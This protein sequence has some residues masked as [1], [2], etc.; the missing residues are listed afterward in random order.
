MAGLAADSAAGPA[1][2]A[3]GEEDTAM[4]PY[5]RPGID[6]RPDYE[7]ALSAEDKASLARLASE[8][9]RL[10]PEASAAQPG[11]QSA[12]LAADGVS[13]V[14][15]AAVDAAV[16][17]YASSFMDMRDPMVSAD[18][19]RPSASDMLRLQ[20]ALLLGALLSVA[21]WTTLTMIALPNQVARVHGF[22]TASDALASQDAAA[23]AAPLAWTVAIGALFAVLFTPFV[24]TISDHTRLPVGRRTPWLV[25]GGL[26]SALFALALGATNASVLVGLLWVLLQ[27]TYA[28]VAAPLAAAIAERVPD[29]FR[30][31]T[32]RWH[33]V[34]VLAGQ[35]AGGV[36]GGLSIAFGAFDPFLCAA[37]MFALSG[38]VVVLVWPREASSSSQ[39]LVR[40]AWGQVGA[41]LRPPLGRGTRAFHTL[42]ASRLFMSAAAGT[43]GAFL[44]YVVRFA[45]YGD[46]PRFTSAPVTLPAGTLLSLLAVASFAGALL[47]TCCGGMI[48]DK[49]AEG[50]GAWWRGSRSAVALACAL[51][52]LGLCLGLAIVLY[53]GEKS[54]TAFSFVA[55]FA[56]GMYDVLVQP[57]VVDALPDP[58]SAGRDLGVYATARPLGLALGTAAGAWSAT[59]LGDWTHPLSAG[60]FGYMAVFP[61]GIVCVALAVLCVA[62]TP[63]RGA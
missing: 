55:G 49:F 56:A 30:D 8:D 15:A 28:M 42:Y 46:M 36:A 53:G 26:L 12:R 43:T 18:G 54:L 34:G 20:W 14:A 25:G 5:R 39:P 51:Y 61:A 6:D 21:P 47:A 24:S 31:E 17:D 10:P 19:R 44:W 16:P 1:V 48:T 52:A 29:K 60:A 3:S 22:D 58:R 2:G 11:A 41:A 62:L 23:L 40:F 7:K 27:C 45:V 50:F 9:R 33:A 4:E 38:V 32:E 63:K 13:A 35:L 37:V 57:L 59:E